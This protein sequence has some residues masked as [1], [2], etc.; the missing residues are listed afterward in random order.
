MSHRTVTPFNERASV[1]GSALLPFSGPNVAAPTSQT[2]RQLAE[3]QPTRGPTPFIGPVRPQVSPVVATSAPAREVVTQQRDQLDREETLREQSRIDF[4]Q[5]FREQDAE[6]QLREEQRREEDLVRDEEEEDRRDPLLIQQ[7]ELFQQQADF[8]DEQQRS[9]SR[10]MAE[11]REDASDPSTNSLLS[12]V[13][14]IFDQ[15]AQ[16]SKELSSRLV[17]GLTVSTIRSGIGRFAPFRQ[18]SILEAEEERGM[19]R[20]AQIEG[21]RRTAAAEAEAAFRDGQTSS[22]MASMA[23]M[24][25]L[26]KQ[27]QQAAKDL[28][29]AT[30]DAR[31][32]AQDAAKE[33][34]TQLEFEQEQDELF[35]DEVASLVAGSLTGDEAADQATIAQAAEEFGIGVPQRLENAVRAF[36]VNQRKG[37]SADT[38]SFLEARDLGFIGQDTSFFDFRAQKAAAGRAP[39][40]AKLL[41]VQ[42]AN[43]IGLPELEGADKD[44]VIRTLSSDV[45][46]QWFVDA[47]EGRAQASLPG[48]TIARQWQSFQDDPEVERLRTGRS[49]T[50]GFFISGDIG[51]ASTITRPE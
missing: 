40:K 19:K 33:A 2:A 43:N 1:Q 22:F 47:Q 26:Q 8:I 34:R 51:G 48:E 24:A 4:E 5:R 27:R 21:E 20:L 50:Q 16:E 42:D 15:R 9:L 28:F 35:L 32:R 18:T 3:E 41:S 7:E 10:R 46:P 39:A 38:R 17:K 37:F 14:D 36:Q 29:K 45:P 44:A 11:I 25:E 23:K 30:L 49:Q 6:R 31:D 12:R 13:N